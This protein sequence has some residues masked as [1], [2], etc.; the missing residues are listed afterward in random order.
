MA[1]EA[2][3]ISS[4]GMYCV[5]LAGEKLF[6]SEEDK[7]VFLELLEKYFEGGEI[8]GHNLTDRE[9]RLVVKEAPK[10]ISMTMKPL[11][12]SY[13]RYYNRTY[14]TSGKLFSGRFASVPL[15][16]DKEKRDAVKNLSE[17]LPARKKSAGDTKPAKKDGDTKTE[18][19][20]KEEKRA[21]KKNMPSYL[22]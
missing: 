10:G 19:P 12:T 3:K 5:K 18:Q 17:A 14:N 4:M 8:Y 21:K 16:S 22:L 15:E 20:K 11:I 2:R 1:R 6:G 7:S 9:I 13:A